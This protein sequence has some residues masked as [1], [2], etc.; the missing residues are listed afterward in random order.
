MIMTGTLTT[1]QVTAA[2]PAVTQNERSRPARQQSSS[3][4]PRNSSG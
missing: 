2:E 4:G 3:S 1:S